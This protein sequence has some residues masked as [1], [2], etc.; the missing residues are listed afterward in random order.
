MSKEERNKKKN[1][2]KSSFAVLSYPMKDFEIALFVIL[3]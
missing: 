3:C 1:K 2:K